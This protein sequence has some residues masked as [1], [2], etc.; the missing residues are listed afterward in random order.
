ML[1]RGYLGEYH[2]WSAVDPIE[3]IENNKMTGL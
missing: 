3:R 1:T 2:D